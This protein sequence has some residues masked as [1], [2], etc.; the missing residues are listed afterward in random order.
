MDL[1]RISTNECFMCAGMS[2]SLE[3]R[4]LCVCRLMRLATPPIFVWD[5]QC[6]RKTE[7]VS[8]TGFNERHFQKVSGV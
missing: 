4:V 2:L 5:F 7:K 3:T 6:F 8:A 1:R